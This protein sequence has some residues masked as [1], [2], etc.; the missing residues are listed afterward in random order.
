MRGFFDG[1]KFP[2][3]GGHEGAGI[4][5]SVGEG[6]VEFKAGDNV[7]PLGVPQCRQ[8]R[9]CKHPRANICS[10][11][12][13]TM[14]CE[15]RDQG[16]SKFSCR[17]Q[18]ITGGMSTFTEYCV[19]NQIQLC[20]INPAAPLD[21][22]CLF[23]CAISTGYGAAIN[24]ANVRPGS[25]CAVWGLGAIGL[26]IVMGCKNAG[27]S[28]I[29]AIDINPA[30]F[31]VAKH[32]GA[33]DFINPK[34]QIDLTAHILEITDG[35][36]DYTFEAVGAIATMQQAFNSSVVGYGVCVFV[37]VPASGIEYPLVPFNLLMGR[38]LKGTIFGDYKAKDHLPKLVDEF[39][40]GKISVEKFIT[41]KLPL[42]KINEGFE[43]LRKGE[44]VRTVLTIATE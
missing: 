24:S 13:D 29:I 39:V 15:G 40:S 26:A 2:V 5:E 20:K 38:T 32:L 16:P 44:C 33:T 7:I 4:V 14:Y 43:L 10:K 18:E 9:N 21:Q 42:E 41:H 36:A 35:G 30:K 34:D 28:R 6:V 31:P 23:G 37:G 19:V 8:C 27:A 12:L 22:V 17:G 1:V 11:F 25:T 3:I